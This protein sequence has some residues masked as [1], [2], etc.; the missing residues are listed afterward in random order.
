MRGT[1]RW[2]RGLVLAVLAAGALLVALGPLQ[3]EGAEEETGGDDAATADSEIDGVRLRQRD[4]DERWQLEADHA[5]H[6]PGKGITRLR[7]V[8]LAVERERRP[9]LRVRSRT[10]RIEDGNRKV[11]LMEEVEVVDPEGYRLTTDILHYT[12]AESRAETDEPVR[13]VADFGEATGIG[14]TLWT[15]ESRIRLHQQALTTF[16]R[17]PSGSS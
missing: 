10:G 5:A 13:I 11:T 4:G 2:N 3:Q 17:S 16:W 9:P 6:F 14:A 15:A 8:R 12:P 7:T 1:R